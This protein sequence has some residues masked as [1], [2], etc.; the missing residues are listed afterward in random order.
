MS[1]LAPGSVVLVDGPA[2][3][4]R[5]RILVVF[6]SGPLAVCGLSVP[7]VGRV[8]IVFRH[9]VSLFRFPN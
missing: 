3:F 6:G 7:G 9:R 2:G 8:G 5:A 4:I 1:R